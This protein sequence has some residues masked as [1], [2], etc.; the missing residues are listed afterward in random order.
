MTLPFLSEEEIV[1]VSYSL[2]IPSIGINE[3]GRELIWKFWKYF[4]RT[5]LIRYE[6]IS[7]FIYQDATN[8]GGE[9]YHKTL[10]SIIKTPYT[11]VWKSI[12]HLANIIS[13]NDIE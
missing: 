11:N 4:L 13:D 1:S 2:E 7:V 8:N 3:A 10:N 9:S 12:A 5:W 6:H